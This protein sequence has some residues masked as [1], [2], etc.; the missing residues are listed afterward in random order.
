MTRPL[1]AS[2]LVLTLALHACAMNASPPRLANPDPASNPP[3]TA[4]DR[5]PP[6][7]GVITVRP[8]DTVYAVARQYGISPRSIIE[9]NRLA[10]PYLLHVGDRLFLPMPRVHVVKAGDTLSEVARTYRLDFT[11]LVAAND[12]RPP[13]A[14]RVG[15]R[16]QLPGAPDASGGTVVAARAPLSPPPS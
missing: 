1:L 12:L 14:L 2:L 10:P 16:L 15:Q 13:Y 11:R 6:A 5:A 7:D 3:S 4:R 9:A 8:G